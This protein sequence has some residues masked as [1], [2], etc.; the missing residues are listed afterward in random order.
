M[1]FSHVPKNR[2]NPIVLEICFGLFDTEYSVQNYMFFLIQRG[3]PHCL[4]VLKTMGQAHLDLKCTEYSVSKALFLLK[5]KNLKPIKIVVI[6]PEST[7]KTTLARQ[8]AEYY[9]TVWV[10]EYAREFIENLD[11]D[12]MESD[13]LTIA[14]GQIRAEEKLLAKAENILICDTDLIVVQI[15]AEVK[16]GRCANWILEQVEQRDYDLY[17]LCGTDIPWE[18]D[19]QR[20]HPAFRDELHTIYLKTLKKYHKPYVKLVGN[21]A[22]RFNH[23]IEHIDRLLL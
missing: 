23:A 19:A 6:G 15:W 20:E 17:L 5:I 11:R 3:L 14:K 13:L 7:G 22:I 2:E 9:Q 18:F 21:K 8:L 10:K 4:N 16:Y 1:G 12:Y